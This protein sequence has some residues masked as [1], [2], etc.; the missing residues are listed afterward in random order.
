MTQ[1][2]ARTHN[3]VSPVER[4][5]E[6]SDPLVAAPEEHH[7]R[8]LSPFWRHYLEMAGVMALGMF[9]SGAILTVAS[10]LKSWNDVT[11]KYPTEAL[12]VMAAGMSIPMVAWMLFRRMGWKSSYE[13]AAAMVL[14]VIP[15]LCLVW[16]GVTKSAWCGPYCISTFVAMFVLMRYRHSE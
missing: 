5:Q 8:R 11:I 10:G 1:A 2:Q 3:R 15:F 6:P 12:V 13:M 7:W 14:P 4:G 16:F 9:V